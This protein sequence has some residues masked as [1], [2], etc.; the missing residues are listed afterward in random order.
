M[1]KRLKRFLIVL[2]LLA[3]LCPFAIIGLVAIRNSRRT[4][5]MVRRYETGVELL[6]RNQLDKAKKAFIDCL[7]LD[8]HNVDAIAHL[9]EIAER[10]KNYPLAIRLWDRARQLDATNTHFKRRILENTLLLR[11]FVNASLLLQALPEAERTAPDRELQ[12]IFCDM[13]QGDPMHAKGA[14]RDFQKA[15]P[16]YKSDLLAYM[17][18]MMDLPQKRTLEEFRNACQTLLESTMSPA[19]QYETLLSLA[20]AEKRLARAAKDNDARASHTDEAIRL[21]TRAAEVNP[22]CG[23]AALGEFLFQCNRDKECVQ[24]YEKA[25]P[26]GLLLTDAI[27]YGETLLRLGRTD[28]LRAFAKNF[29]RGSRPVLQAGYY[30]EGLLAYDAHDLK[31]MAT[32]LEHTGNFSHLTT[33]GIMLNVCAALYGENWGALLR[34]VLEIRQQAQWQRLLPTVRE[35]CQGLLQKAYQERRFEEAASLAVALSEAAPDKPDRL[36]LGLRLHATGL[37]NASCEPIIQEILRLNPNDLEGLEAA[38]RFYLLHGQPDLC[39]VYADRALAF[40]VEDPVALNAVRCGALE[41]VGR[42][43]E[44]AAD[45]QELQRSPQGNFISA[46][47]WL[48]FCLRH[49]KA[50]PD[51]TAAFLGTIAG[52]QGLEKNLL[53]IPSLVALKGSPR[54]ELRAKTLPIIETLLE[55]K[56]FDATRT[57]DAQLLFELALLLGLCDETQKAVDI[58]LSIR[59]TYPEPVLISMNLSELYA[60]QGKNEYAMKAAT[61]AYVANPNE[62]EVIFCYAK[63]LHEQGRW[64]QLRQLMEPWRGHATYGEQAKRLYDEAMRGGKDKLAP[65]TAAEQEETTDS[66]PASPSSK[67]EGGAD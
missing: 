48:L 15:F 39:V 21:L 32:K 64:S 2:L 16:N 10:Q 52:A 49:A 5:W 26:Y 14:I 11:D 25:L 6:K 56:L 27:Y 35:L 51:Y 58:F 60:A 13:L 22:S 55:A 42:T 4:T 41:L 67:A 40:P 24:A 61:D 43:D 54:E 46:E 38:A 59:D 44:V 65:G 36:L 62:P 57:P 23:H 28:D 18:I 8:E 29:V 47:H 12:R 31:T 3:V 63:R 53:P 50:K 66:P 33:S 19:V 7:Y 34:L 20:A 30:L 1:N 37:A 45:W 9:G 17:E